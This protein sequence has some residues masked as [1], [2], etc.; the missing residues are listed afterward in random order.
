VTSGAGRGGSAPRASARR[1]ALAGAAALAVLA[2][3]ALVAASDQ[4]PAPFTVRKA[5]P[6]GAE[7]GPPPSPAPELRVLLFGDF[8]AA[9]AQQRAVA[10]GLVRAARERPFDLAFSLGDNLYPCGPDPRL[11]GAAA[12]RFE[13]DGATVDAAFTPPADER[14]E[15]LF[16][17]PLDGLRR[18]DAPLPVYL[19]LG[20]H[21]VAG[22]ALCREGELAGP[23]LSRLRACLEVAHRGPR[24]TMPARHYVVDR[25]PARFVVIDSNQLVED[26]GGFT[27]D[28]E[29]EL[30]AEAARTAGD[31]HL[32]VVAHHPAAGAG[33][34][35]VE[36][37]E[38]RVARVRR[39]QEAAGGRIAAWFAGHDHD[40]Q[41]LRAAAGYDVI[42]SGNGA[43]GRPQERFGL[44][45][46]PAAQLLFAST[47]W[48]FA[49]LEVSREHWAVR[50]EG[51]GGEPLHCCHAVPP[52]RCQPVACPVPR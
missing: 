10:K 24:W 44:V 45:A 30:L 25:G 52:G 5:L 3:V 6:R 35:A 28:G 41:H 36:F 38:E 22:Y 8:G 1:T 11:P 31:R 19:A 27:L 17:A 26:S 20:N 23:E 12:C 43:L 46:P 49:S 15:R 7:Q 13:A 40:L 47:A 18:G 37:T 33:V 48:G 29:V 4:R 51:D 21:D 16:E 34:H 2:V 39:L 32:F 42:V 14:F 9:T 50:F